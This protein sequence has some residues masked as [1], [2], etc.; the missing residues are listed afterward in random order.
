MKRMF[1]FAL[2]V[3]MVLG[4]CACNKEDPAEKTG[5]PNF[6]LMT[7][8]ICRY[9][10]GEEVETL[11]MVL[12]YDENYNIIAGKTYLEDRLYTE[13]T[14]GQDVFHPLSQIEYDENGKVCDATTYTYDADGKELSRVT[15]NAAGEAMYSTVNTYNA[16]G[17]LI[18][19]VTTELDGNQ[20]WER[21]TYDDRGNMTSVQYGSG[22]ETWFDTTYENIYDGDKLIQVKSYE[23]DV[24][25]QSASYDAQGNTV[26]EIQYTPEGD[27]VF[28]TE[29]TYENGK[30]L[31]EVHMVGGE[32]HYRQENV[33]N[34]AGELV[35]IRYINEGGYESNTVITYEKG[36]YASIKAYDAGEL[37]M[38]YVFTYRDVSVSPEQAAK[39]TE[40]YKAI[41]DIE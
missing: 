8:A 38:E 4:L 19:A 17:K 25:R 31:R 39:L 22:E 21:Y 26:L 40:L 29:Y 13:A 35:E 28:R 18:S 24:L 7:E 9:I 23:E 20:S 37:E 14:F 6:G 3:L 15:K 34:D 12:E 30:L 33:Y 5:E 10:D 11:K 41:P 16:Q 1:A 2:A 27:E 36:Q 32:E